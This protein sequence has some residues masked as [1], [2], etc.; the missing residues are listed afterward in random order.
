MNMAW[1]C[2][3]RPQGKVDV[4]PPIVGIAARMKEEK[5]E[6]NKLSR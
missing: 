4:Q 2:K 1:V 3:G 6:A 5:T